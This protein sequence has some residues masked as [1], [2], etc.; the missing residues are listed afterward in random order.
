MIKR[1]AVIT[2]GGDSPG[3]N[4]A[5]RAIVR[6]AVYYEIEVFGFLQ[7][8]KGL[9]E[10]S[11]IQLDGRSVSNIIQRGGTIIRSARCPE[12]K[13]PKGR[14]QAAANLNALNIDALLV[15]GGDG[16]LKG[17]S[18]FAEQWQG[19][20][21]GLPGTIDNDLWGTDYTIGY[22]TALDTALDAIDKIRD[23]ADAID[24][25]FLIEVMGRMAGFIAEGVSVAGGA[26]ET[27]VPERP[28]DIESL[29]KSIKGAKQK[30]KVSYIMVVAEGAYDGG[31]TALA[32]QLQEK[33]GIE[34]RPCVLGHVQRGGSPAAL[35]RILA[36]KLGSYAVEQAMQGKTQVM[37]GII[38]NELL[39][40]PMEQAWKNKKPLD[41]YLVSM[42]KMLSQ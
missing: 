26:E 33:S 40:T 5:L 41:A 31:A 11:Y 4:A 13:T 7:A 34:C 17:A 38:N 10:N 29:I 36:S 14:A 32:Q 9:I 37:A 24:R 2:S 23:T 28:V 25:V 16:S 19:Q 42:Q 39:M 30:G 22:F 18:L 6:T 35:D 3:M 20:T 1:I 8:Y 12:F 21:I 15:I 27:L